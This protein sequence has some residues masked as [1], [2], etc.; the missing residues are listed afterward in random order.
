V[1]ATN[2]QWGTRAFQKLLALYPG[3]FR[4]EYGR[5]VAMVFAD[6]YRRATSARQRAQIWLDGLIGILREA[7]KEHLTTIAHDL[8]FAA[9]T[10][11][12]SPGFSAT[13]VLTLALGIGAN[14]AIFQL[15]NAVRLQSLPI[16]D[17][18]ELAEVRIVGG[19]Q[20]FGV[21]NGRYAQLTRP[22]WQELRAHQQA[23]SAVFAWATPD[24]RVGEMS[25]LRSVNGIAVSGE[26]F[27]VLGIQPWRGRLI[28][29]SDEAA[30]PGSRAVVSHAYWQRALGGRELGRDVRLRINGGYHEVIGVTPP[31]FFGL[32]VGESFDVAVPLCQ[33]KSPRREVFDVS[34]MGRL[35]PGWTM[36]RASDHLATLSAGIFEASMPVGYS[37]QWV[38]RFKAFRLA[39][40]PASAGVS[41]LRAS[42]DT[43]LNLL[44][45]ITGLVLLIA[46]ANLANLMLARAVARSREVSVRLT[47]GASRT[48]LLRQFLAESALLATIGAA[49]GVGLAQV[50]SRGLLRALSAQGA[51]PTL[52]LSTDLRVLLF[53]GAVAIA[54]CIV[55][56]LAPA[57]RAMHARPVEALRAGG[58]TVT[59]GRGRFSTQ[60][61]M[62]VTQI[63]VSL[64][65]LVA[66]LLFVRSFRN[67]TTFDPGMRR[68]GIV[69]GRVG[70]GQSGIPPGRFNDFQRELVA[71]VKAIPGVGNAATATQPPLLGASWGHDVTIGGRRGGTKFTWVGPEYFATM[72]IPVIGGRAFTLR[73]TAAS[74]RVAI[75][76]QAFV[77]L[78]VE[79]G[80]PIGQTLR[81]SAEPRY[82]TTAYEI[83]G[84]IGDTRYSSLRD[85]TPPMA[86][87]PDS[88]YPDLGP[89]AN[90]MIHSTVEPAQT[91]AAVRNR[92]RQ[93]HPEIFMEFDDFGQRI[94][95]GLTRERLLALLASFFGALATLLATVGLY[96]MVS[97]TMAQR[98]QEIGIRTAMGA[99]RQQIVGLVMRDA[100]WLMAAGVIGGAAVSLLVTRSAATLLF[101]LTPHDPSTL[102][103]ACLILAVVA[104]TASFLP[105]R[106]VSRLDALA[107]MRDQ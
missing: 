94:L 50:L 63:A 19:R 83:V 39:A 66:A 89:W 71:T 34:V 79:D 22:V 45:A 9:R 97:F 54:A 2:D 82:P 59:V 92:L 100:A 104:A 77:R 74:P 87:A 73:D 53:T 20:G 91:I 46:C 47:L 60:R 51:S 32:A 68:D 41:Q 52:T 62:V 8:R 69:V 90:I 70:F 35:G 23:L 56:G 26:F 40:Y 28:E 27:G 105:A 84:V 57:I 72:G 44:L 24:L 95:D 33:P 93:G 36:K 96:G 88:Q 7:P 48:R 64:I 31:G 25:D 12:R 18:A 43:P 3:E 42:Y 86:F 80:D 6:R 81:T 106:R 11:R 17:A 29:P 99:R 13:V 5:E 107:A 101:G 30:C 75:V 15:I 103:A 49:A 21:G 37:A 67:L 1:P 16:R 55:F 76:N 4:D 58:R 14:T 10:A 65:L 61:L 85:E 98:R 102:I 78:L 38:D